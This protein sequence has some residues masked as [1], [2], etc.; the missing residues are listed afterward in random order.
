MDLEKLKGDMNVCSS[1]T[2]DL[3]KKTN[4]MVT[5]YVKTSESRN[6]DAKEDRLLLDFEE[7]SSIKKS[8]RGATG[9][10]SRRTRRN[11]LPLT[12][13]RRSDDLKLTSAR[14]NQFVLNG[15][16]IEILDF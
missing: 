3:N 16:E 4:E 14:T 11:G 13:N 6:N 5:E 7:I 8:S 9:D 2:N 1:F 12:S 15:K 10:I